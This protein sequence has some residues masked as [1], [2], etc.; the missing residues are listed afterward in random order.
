MR[1]F[2][3]T[4]RP[5]RGLLAATCL[6]Y[7]AAFTV[8]T[9]YFYGWHLWLGWTALCLS[10]VHSWRVQTLRHTGA[11]GKI[12]IDRRGGAVV[13]LPGRGKAAAA[14]LLDDSLIHRRICFL[15]WQM[16]EGRLWQCLPADA[17]EYGDYRRLLLW[18]RFGRPKEER[19]PD[20]T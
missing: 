10:A 16:Q 12:G 18:A 11:V 7:A 15:H 20:E 19:N 5:S 1:P 8:C 14:I 2:V 3:L 6:F 13:F 17:A 9:L 4:I